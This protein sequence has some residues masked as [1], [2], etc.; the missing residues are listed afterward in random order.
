MYNVCESYFLVEDNKGLS[1]TPCFF[2]R[3]A[4]PNIVLLLYLIFQRNQISGIPLHIS[5]S[6]EFYP[7]DRSASVDMS[8]YQHAYESTRHIMPSRFNYVA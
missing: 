3:S 6:F 7:W 4:D 5:K 1:L 8:K 2:G